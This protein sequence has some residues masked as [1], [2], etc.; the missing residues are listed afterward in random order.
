LQ[1]VIRQRYSAATISRIY[2][3]VKNYIDH[4]V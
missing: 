1:L 4:A 3:V 2:Q